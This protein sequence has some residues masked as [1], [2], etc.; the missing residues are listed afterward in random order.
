M[1]TPWIIKKSELVFQNRWARVREDVCLLPNGKEIEY[2]YWDGD[3]YVL[4]C[5]VTE[6]ERVVVTRQYKNAVHQVILELP[7][8]FLDPEDPSPLVAA[9]RELREE[10]GY[11]G[12]DWAYL[13]RFIVSS[14]KSTAWAHLFF[15]NGV[16]KTQGQELDGQEEIEIVL[17]TKEETMEMIK[18]GELQDLGSITACFMALQ[19]MGQMG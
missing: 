9:Q 3:D 2:Y 19:R 1:P 4:I 17:P 6:D 7:A 16:V 11:T 14:S 13:G 10:T 5:A 18:K 8:G 15:A 12:G